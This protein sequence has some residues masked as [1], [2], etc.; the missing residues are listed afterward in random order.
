LTSGWTFDSDGEFSESVTVSFT[1]GATFDYSGVGT[2]RYGFD[3]SGNIVG[4]EV[5]SS[6]AGGTTDIF[7]LYMTPGDYL[8]TS[9]V[10]DT[11]GGGIGDGIGTLR[12]PGSS[13]IYYDA[14]ADAGAFPVNPVPL[15]S[16]GMLLMSGFL[17]FWLFFT[18]K[19]RRQF[20][21][22]TSLRA[23]LKG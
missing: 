21:T 14:H 1:S 23:S 2:W 16:G 9:S 4:F 12:T 17:G 6:N 13:P 20:W 22:S 3:S 10:P 5:D 19:P 18:R 7:D 15:P 8:P 11:R